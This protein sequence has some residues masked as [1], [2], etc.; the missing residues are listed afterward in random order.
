MLKRRLIPCILMSDGAL[1]K[2]TKFKDPVYV[3]DPINTVRIFNEKEV[4]ELVILDI[5]TRQLNRQPDFDLIQKIAAEAFMPVAYGGG[6]RSVEDASRILS[7]GVEKI[8]LN[9]AAIHNP[10]LLSEIASK[11]GSQSV[12]VSVDVKKN[13]FGQYKLFNFTKAAQV[14]ALSPLEFALFCETLGAGEIF[15]NA[16]DRDGTQKGYD[17]ELITL[18]LS[19]LKVPLVPCGG[20][21]NLGDFKAV[22]D[23][24][25]NAA[26]AGSF[27]VFQGPHRAVLVSYPTG[28]VETLS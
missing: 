23:A 18:F 12:V 3:G 2:T 27:F 5:S 24:G 1:V 11:F 20:A 16:V 6:I 7:S 15:L 9:Q 21:G 28:F 13:W 26:A 17:L 22:Y 8:V 25:C 19:Q 10:G 4:D 14:E